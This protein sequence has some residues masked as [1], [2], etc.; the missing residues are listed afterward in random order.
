MWY[1]SKTD[2]DAVP[3]WETPDDAGAADWLS[4]QPSSHLSPLWAYVWERSSIRKVARHLLTTLRLPRS[5][6]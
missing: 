4:F 1:W 5:R 3:R 6:R 2:N